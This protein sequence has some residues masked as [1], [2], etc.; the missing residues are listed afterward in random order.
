METRAL[1]IHVT[2]EAAQA[3]ETAT[4]EV[5]RQVDGLLSRRLREAMRNLT[6]QNEESGPRRSERALALLCGSATAGMTTDEILGL[7][8]GE[9]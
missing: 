8:R 3:Y 2:P 5:R 7:T 4:P 1:T 9:E 6:R